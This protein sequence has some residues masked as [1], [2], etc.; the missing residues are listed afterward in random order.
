MPSAHPF[1]SLQGVRVL[2]RMHAVCNHSGQLPGS[3]DTDFM[4]VVSDGLRGRFPAFAWR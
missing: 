4:V 2:S 1:H 3:R